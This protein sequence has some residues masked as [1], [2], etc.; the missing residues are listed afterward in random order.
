MKDLTLLLTLV[1]ML[2]SSAFA[3]SNELP[4]ELRI[5]RQEDYPPY[6]YEKDGELV[7]ICTELVE[8][9]F[10][11]LGISVSYNEYPFSRMLKKA[12]WGQVDAVMMVF[13][14][15]ERE[16]YLYYP[17][18]SLFYEHNSFFVKKSTQIT[19]SGKLEELRNYA[20]GIVFG[21]SYGEQ[22]DNAAYI[23][24][25]VSANHELLLRKLRG[26]RFKVGLGNKHVV[27]FYADT[28]GFEDGIEFLEPNHFDK[29]PLYV[30]FTKKVPGY[31]KLAERFSQALDELKES[32]QYQQILA[33]YKIQ[34]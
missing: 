14:T 20:I 16:E 31:D 23:E 21:F 2:S 26:N 34:Q 13:R 5:A 7:G 27:Q 17:D 6:I 29:E 4:K 24:K 30:A 11:L 33:K 15:P 12:E 18:N 3:L 1:S 8:A 22:F 32:G 9:A 25:E 19:Y 28:I 10:S